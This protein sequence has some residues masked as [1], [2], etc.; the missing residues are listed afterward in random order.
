MLVLIR[1]L[2]PEDYGSAALAE[3]IIGLLSVL[4]F[5]TFVS[6]ALQARD[7]ADIDW[8]C[9]FTAAVVG[10]SLLTLLTLGLA[11]ILSLT[12]RHSAVAI[13][14]AV[15]S[16]VFIVEV[17]AALRQRML[18][19]VHDWRRFR[20]LAF[21]GTLMGCSTGIVIAVLGGG[22]WALVVQP[23][24]FG[25]PAALDLLLVAKWRPQLSWNWARYRPT[26]GFGATRVVAGLLRNGRHI[27]EQSLLAG[28]Y[29]FAGLG[30]FT[31]SFGLA[32]LVAGRLAGVAVESIYPVIT[33]AERGSAQF[34]RYAGLIMRGV[35]WATIPAAVLLATTAPEVVALLYGPKWSEVIPLVPLSAIAVGL[36]AMALAAQALLLA[37]NELRKCLVVD[38]VSVVLGVVL[39]VWLVPVGMVL[40]LAALVAHGL[41]LLGIAIVL[42]VQSGGTDRASI[43]AAFFPAIIAAAVAFGAVIAGSLTVGSTVVMPVRLFL[44]TAL[45]CA[46]YLVVLRLVFEQSL[47]ELIEVAPAGDRLGAM[48]ALTPRMN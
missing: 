45:F 18:Q 17:P 15:L 10:N 6:H 19:V 24:V 40:Y 36:G 44:E 7:P 2:Q 4:S 32:T 27:V 46:V 30:V 42:L 37:N 28:T 3:S 11:A 43:S 13:P 8:Q 16:L 25:L 1:L 38:V 5:G 39:A 9:H 33:R 21:Y 29:Q 12:S 26:A 23:V 31:R 22:V 34:R 14:L 48:L 20:L 35:A 47:R 41:I